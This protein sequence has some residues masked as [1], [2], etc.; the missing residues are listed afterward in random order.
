M[1]LSR[2][3]YLNPHPKTFHPFPKLPIEIRLE[4]W[5][6][7]IK[8]TFVN[9][10]WSPARRRFTSPRRPPAILQCDRESRQYG[11]KTYQLSFASSPDLA[12]IYFSYAIDVVWF[13]WSTLG[14]SPG[15]LGRKI[16][17]EEAEKIENLLVNEE[18][19]LEHA[20]TNSLGE[21]E[22]FKGLKWIGVIC[23]PADPATG[24]EYGAT[25]MAIMSEKLNEA[26]SEKW[27]HLDFLR[28]NFMDGECS[29]HW[30]FDGWNQRASCGMEDK[31]PKQLARCLMAT[32]EG[33]D[34]DF[35]LDLLFNQET[36]IWP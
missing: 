28:Y 21:L 22:R 14:P 17:D 31:W 25:E 12:Q 19:L 8:P 30:W 6:F 15:R 35:W 7:T 11:L 23:D 5:G 16:S 26:G 1:S 32:A 13:D 20:E 18:C 4:I 27:P 2:Q 3:V 10:S 24:D 36:F 9:I 33:D 29:R 34:A